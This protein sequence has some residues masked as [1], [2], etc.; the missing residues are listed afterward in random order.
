MRTRTAV[1]DASPP[2]SIGMPRLGVLVTLAALYA[3]AV[4]LGTLSA[5]GYRHASGIVDLGHA[6]VP[7]LRELVGERKAEWIWWL[8]TL[9]LEA[10]FV[11][12]A[13]VVVATGKGKRLALCLYAMYALHWLFLLATTLPPP[14]GIVWRFPAGIV[15]LGHP[16]AHD[17]WFS[18]HV[19]NAFV[20]A[21]AT[22]SARPWVRAIAWFGVA[23]ETALVLST[24]THYSIDVIGA[25]FVGYTAHRVSLDLVP[26]EVS[27]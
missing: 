17:L 10:F 7:P 4:A 24:R 1:D 16:T 9:P 19:A 21:L 27:A 14:D 22:P 15:T 11:V 25:F 26:A 8:G 6:L 3:S 23:F 18:G 20:I 12:I 13:A 5:P 2:A